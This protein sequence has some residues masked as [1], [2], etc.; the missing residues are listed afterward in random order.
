MTIQTHTDL[1]QLT[2]TVT[3]LSEALAA[4]ERR[5]SAMAQAIRWGALTFIVLVAATAYAASDM[6]KAYAAN[7]FTWDQAQKMIAKE[8]PKL[9]SILMS[10]MDSKELT[11]TIVKVMQSASMLAAHETNSY[12]ACV[13]ERQKLP[14]QE[15]RDNKLC[16]SKAA[17]EDLGMFYLDDNNELPN[18]PTPDASPQEKMAYNMKM[19]EGTLMAAGQS[20]VDGAALIHRL[21][22]DSDLVRNTVNEIGGVSD[23]LRG[24]KSELH[25]MNGM[26]TSIPA[27]ANEMNV[28]NR[29]ISVMSYSVGSTMGRMGSVMPW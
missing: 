7:S 26:L 12:L 6:V 16:Y 14:T 3:R 19:M 23:L 18:P 4:S 5:H 22:R 11:G 24:I 8:N 2:E 21:R 29:Q 25:M 9:D 10:F 28:M 15:E 13:D 20:I 27:M 17:V 1:Q